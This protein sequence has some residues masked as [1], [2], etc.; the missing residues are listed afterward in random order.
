VLKN[1]VLEAG[2]LLQHVDLQMYEQALQSVRDS[3]VVWVRTVLKWI[4]EATKAAFVE[5]RRD[6]GHDL[7]Y[8]SAK[9]RGQN[10]KMTKKQS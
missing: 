8:P 7:G 4:A 5:K 2:K 6:S 9:Q 10:P 1:L 3:G